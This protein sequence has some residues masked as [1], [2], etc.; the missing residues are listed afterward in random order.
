MT[1]SVDNSTQQVK[2]V[3]HIGVMLMLVDWKHTCCKL[4]EISTVSRLA[5]FQFV[6]LCRNL[7]DQRYVATVLDV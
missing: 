6:W 3:P 1:H 2:K 5:L 7:C 4:A